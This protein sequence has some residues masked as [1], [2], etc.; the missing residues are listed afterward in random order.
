VPFQD[1]ARNT[2]LFLAFLFLPVRT[3]PWV[4]ALASISYGVYLCHHLVIEGL[5]HFERFARLPSNTAWVTVSR[6]ACGLVLS[7]GLSFLLSKH[8]FT[9]WLVR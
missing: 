9:A 2:F 4:A 7:A 1:I 3:P 6:F 5:L 8:R